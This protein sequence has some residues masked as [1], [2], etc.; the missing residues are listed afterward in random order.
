MTQE[1]MLQ[2]LKKDVRSL[3]MSAKM[4]LAPEQ[5]RRDY[6]SML[7][8]PM[9]LKAL[10]FANI[11]DMA[12]EMPDV[13]SFNCLADG[14][15]ILKAVGNECTR[16]IEELV[17]K[18]RKT[19]A[20]VKKK[21]GGFGSFSSQHR[22]QT[23][24]VVLP[25]WSRAPLALP[26]QLRAQVRQLLS[27]GPLRLSELETSFLRCF[28]HPLR[29]TN[30]GFYSVGEMLEAASDL[31]VVQPGLYGS[32]LTLKEQNRTG[33][34]GGATQSD[35]DGTRLEWFVND[36]KTE[37]P[38]PEPEPGQEG[39]LF[40]KRVIKLEV[41]LRQ[42][43]LENSDAGT[44]SPELKAKLQQVVGQS[45]E[46]LSVH[47]LPTEYKRLFGE[48]L[49]VLQSGF[50]SVTE[51]VGAMSDVFH[52]KPAGGDGGHH[53]LVIDTQSATN[54]QPGECESGGEG[55]N[56]HGT[57]YYLDCG[58]SPWE[59]SSTAPDHQ[60]HHLEISITTN[61]L[62]QMPEMYPRVQV[63]CGLAGPL[64]ALRGQR[65]KPP[66][67]YRSRE[68][69]AVLVEHVETPSRFYVRFVEEARALEDMMIEMRRCYSCPEVSERYRLPERLV[70]QGQACCV[71][72]MVAWFYRVVIHR[73]I[74]SSL[75]EVYYVDFG[76]LSTVETSKLKFLKSCYS[77][78]PAQAVPSCLTG[79][80]PTAG[81]WTAD[82]TASFRKLCCQRPL[83][84]ALDG[85]HDDVLQ[86]LLCDTHTEDDL[87]VHC[88]L[89]TQGHAEACSHATSAAL[90]PVS[91]YLGEGLFDLGEEGM[92]EEEA[93]PCTK[94]PITA[95]PCQQPPSLNT[96]V[97]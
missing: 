90:N 59:D 1:E 13:V 65:L 79:A 96:K 57:S 84:A 44:I 25:R 14:S 87:Y 85:Y 47:D 48:E 12:K 5:L 23:S 77:D 80:R 92:D 91:C 26:V 75:V 71:S 32:V 6:S 53:W 86:I 17:A 19:K 38:E 51:L 81:S 55:L 74:S 94:P 56:Q 66:T 64:D 30:Y 54:T 68:L 2:N 61:T 11:L 41:E 42:R 43:M 27:Q 40:Q 52:L 3:L 4:G 46:G 69:V 22:H 39:R 24:P 15:L 62:Q 16:G 58:D 45:S 70:R 7:G 93:T 88:V 20:D 10:G 9:P 8:H 78:L 72:P 29:V 76:D 97:E 89:Q 67:R 50:L 36:D 37:P 28:G 49:P 18:Q 60:N 35:V 34:L 73:V 63:Q 83:V 31:V 21:R 33:M 82:A 95:Q